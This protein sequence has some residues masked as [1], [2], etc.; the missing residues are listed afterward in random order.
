MGQVGAKTPA[1]VAHL[2]VRDKNNV[3]EETER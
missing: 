3:L 2:A 1:E